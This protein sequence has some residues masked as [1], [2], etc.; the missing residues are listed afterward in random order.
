MKEYGIIFYFLKQFNFR[1]KWV[2]THTIRLIL[3]HD[4]PLPDKLFTPS[5]NK[6]RFSQITAEISNQG[7]KKFF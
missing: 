4:L 3:S 2:H 6:G 7:K 1:Q 5:P